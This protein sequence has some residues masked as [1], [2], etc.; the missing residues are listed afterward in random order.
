MQPI[1]D[2]ASRRFSSIPHVHTETS[3]ARAVMPKNFLPRF[4]PLS[5]CS[6]LLRAIF[7]TFPK[8]FRILENIEDKFL[9]QI[10]YFVLEFSEK[11]IICSFLIYYILST[12]TYFHN[13]WITK[14]LSSLINIFMKQPVNVPNWNILRLYRSFFVYFI[15]LCH[16]VD[17]WNVD[18]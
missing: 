14:Y 1:R 3:T 15:K 6:F 18:F 11:V 2:K 16:W 17:S 13:V 10:K 8:H 7:Y 12:Q 4:S 5:F 9:L